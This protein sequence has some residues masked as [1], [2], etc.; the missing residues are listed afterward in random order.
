MTREYRFDRGEDYQ[1]KPAFLPLAAPAAEAAAALMAGAAAGAST[2][3][4]N[5]KGLNEKEKELA[6]RIACPAYG[7]YKMVK[8]DAQPLAP[9]EKRVQMGLIQIPMKVDPM[10][11]TPPSDWGTAFEARQED[12]QK[13]PPADFSEKDI[14]NYVDI[15][16]APH[17]ETDRQKAGRGLD[18]HGPRAESEF[19][20]PKGNAEE[21]NRQGI[22][23]MEKILRDPDVREVPNKYGGKDVVLP[24]GKGFRTNGDGT[25][26]GFLEPN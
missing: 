7:M 11:A 16:K 26:R 4:N 17:K 9:D 6:L 23:E 24:N 1:L 2:S 10:T 8:E 19:P 18:K 13:A 15:G 25:F 20:C 14:Q 22:Q 12:I 21:V 3:E 5:L